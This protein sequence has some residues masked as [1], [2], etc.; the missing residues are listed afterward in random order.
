MPAAAGSGFVNLDPATPAH[1]PGQGFHAR[2][3]QR[4]NHTEAQHQGYVG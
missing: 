4:Q 1:P 3:R 2:S